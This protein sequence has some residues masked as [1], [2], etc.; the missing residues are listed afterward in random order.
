VRRVVVHNRLVRRYNLAIGL[1][2]A[3]R[4]GEALPIFREVAGAAEDPGLRRLAWERATDPAGGR[5]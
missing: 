1:L 2:N 4:L 5:R 3:G